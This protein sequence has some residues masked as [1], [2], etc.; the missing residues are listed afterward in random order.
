MCNTA[1]VSQCGSAV[2]VWVYECVREWVWVWVCTSSRTAAGSSGQEQ[3]DRAVCVPAPEVQHFTMAL[4]TARA[5][6]CVFSLLAVLVLV[7]TPV[8]VL[9]CPS[10]C[11]CFRTTVRCMHLNLEAV[12]TV[13]PQTTILWVHGLFS[14]TLHLSTLYCCLVWFGLC[15]APG[16]LMTL[17]FTL[18]KAWKG[19]FGV[20]VQFNG[21][22][23]FLCAKVISTN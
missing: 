3:A 18:Q 6:P 7:L 1:L 8:P 9:P 10:R 21:S 5:R 12:P 4:W 2:C 22:R 23:L 15:F 16:A 13:S 11:L 20:T 17:V 19:A 14:N